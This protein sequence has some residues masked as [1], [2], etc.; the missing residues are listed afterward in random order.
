M[1]T[2]DTAVVEAARSATG[3][4]RSCCRRGYGGRG[5]VLAAAHAAEDHRM[6]EVG[7]CMLGGATH[8]AHDSAQALHHAADD[9]RDTAKEALD[10][11]HHRG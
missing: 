11:G 7:D 9:V 4:G 10:A 3:A 6:G 2:A 5:G 8:M 1:S